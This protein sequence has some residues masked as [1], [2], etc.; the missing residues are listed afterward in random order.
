MF[1]TDNGAKFEAPAHGTLIDTA[2][3]EWFVTYHA[4]E[5][6]YYSLGRQMLMQ[7]IEWTADGWWKPVAGK[8]P[9]A[10]AKAPDLPSSDL[11]FQQ[12]DEFDSADLGVQ[13]FF[14]AAP[15]M[16][17]GTWSLKDKPG[18]LRIHSVAGDLSSIDALPAIFQQRV[19][20]KKF[21]FETRVTFD[22]R[23]GH[24]AAGLHMFHDPLMNFW[25]ASTVVNG[26]KRVEVGKYNLGK[27][28]DLWS[29]PNPGG[30]SVSLRVDVDGQESAT[31]SFSPD[32]KAW[33]KIGQSIYFGA[34]G[35]HL[36]DSQRGDPDLGWVGRYKDRTATPAEISGVPNPR[37]PTR[38]GNI[39]TATTFG[40]FA[41]RD[42]AAQAR[43]ADFEY[44]R[45][46][47][48]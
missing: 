3:G 21:S 47:K 2:K 11:H 26:E 17:G 27:R 48:P 9:T 7:P 40:V 42:G 41:V 6:A 38:A 39:W 22:P 10:T 30:A 32:G 29:A 1:S 46:T 13:W 20:D 44:F 31:F 12:S 35:H 43:D 16:T 37:L 25:L 23:D 36:R 24:E 8:V 4:H 19:I 28:T 5:T 15:D 18:S 45:V 33:Q 14:T 34:S